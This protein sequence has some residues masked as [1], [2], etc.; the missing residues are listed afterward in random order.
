[1]A[2][3]VTS[4]E[5]LAVTGVW[6]NTRPVP[7]MNRVLLQYEYALMTMDPTK[8]LSKPAHVSSKS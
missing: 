8:I 3:S 1:M 5:A 7:G 6:P 2:T 4:T